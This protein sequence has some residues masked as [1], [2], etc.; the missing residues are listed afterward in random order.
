MASVAADLERTY[1][2][3]EGRGAHIE[4]LDHV[5]FGAIRPGLALL[6]GAVTIGL[7]IGCVNVGGLL[8][9]KGTTRT[10]EIAVRG[11][12]G[13]SV[14]R[15]ARQFA[16]ETILLTV[17]GAAVGV[18]LAYVGLHVLLAI[19]PADIP[20]VAEVHIDVRMLI[21][22]LVVSLAVGLTF[23]MM[24]TLQA[25]RVNVA[26]A[27]Q[28]IRSTPGRTRARVR[29]A[30]AIAELALATV[31]LIADTLLL[32][33]FQTVLRTDPGFLAEGVLKAEYQL[34]D[35]RYPRDYEVWP[36]WTEIQTFNREVVNRVRRIPGVTSVAL[37]SA[38]P[39]DSGATNSFTIVGREAE[40]TNWPE[41]AR[42]A[43]SPDYFATMKLARIHGRILSDGDAGRSALVAAI[44]QATADLLFTGREPVGQQ[45]RFGGKVRTIVGVVA[46]ER[47]HGLTQKPPLAVYV[48]L[49]QAPAAGGVILVRTAGKPERIANDVRKAIWSVD[50]AL[51]LYG[52]EPLTTTIQN[53]VGERR[54]TMLI[55]GA[56]GAL[57]IVIALIGV[58][59]MMSYSTM[60]RTR[61]FGIRIALGATRG[62]VQWNV[63]GGGVRLAAVAA[64]VGIGGALLATRWIAA[65][66]F[67]VA[68]TDVV[69]YAGVTIAVVMA[70]AVASWLPVRRATRIQTLSAISGE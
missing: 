29:N 55:V 21:V 9:A 65:M 33:I 36:N 14:T 41:I 63:V 27:L 52:V 4:T 18:V 38:Q 23:G 20:R 22:T 11:A 56:F 45:I 42:R 68:A 12:L 66:L 13:A 6:I 61:E 59:G 1:G 53:S 15:L 69:T 28:S 26:P 8:L 67:G 32:R 50:A 70:A 5:V 62:A 25:I 19:A 35:A 60:Q 3:N 31:L 48:P 39:L 57:A 58:H 34:P 44:N 46:N 37:A 54:F 43:V 64:T 16:A 49:A 7:L 2:V 10:R 17:I 40:A 24:S 30:L 51:P 47:I